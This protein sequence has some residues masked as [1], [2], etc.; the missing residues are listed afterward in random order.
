MLI[1]VHVGTLPGSPVE[2]PVPVA[3]PVSCAVPVPVPH[4][5]VVPV[6]APSV[7]LRPLRLPPLLP[8]PAG[9]NILQTRGAPA[10]SNNGPRL[11][12]Q[13]QCWH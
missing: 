7:H 13:S 8:L 12:K 9:E 10:K 2:V 11:P 1:G 5:S 4:L 6:F 3:G